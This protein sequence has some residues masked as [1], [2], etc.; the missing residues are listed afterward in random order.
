MNVSWALSDQEREA[1]YFAMCLLIPE[2]MI[3]EDCKNLVIMLHGNQIKELAERYQVSELLMTLRLQEL[4][5]I[6]FN[7]PA[8]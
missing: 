6:N 8:R 7:I 4:G 5:I 3:K 2:Q 1:N